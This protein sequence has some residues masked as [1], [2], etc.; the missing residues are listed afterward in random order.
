MDSNQAVIWND[1]QIIFHGMKPGLTPHSDLM[2]YRKLM[3]DAQLLPGLDL[4]NGQHEDYPHTVIITVKHPD[5]VH[6][7][8]KSLQQ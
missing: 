4:V 7:H 5:G 8:G 2:P 1:C 3:P 6:Q